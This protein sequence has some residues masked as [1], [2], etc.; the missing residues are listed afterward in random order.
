MPRTTINR[1]TE[2]HAAPQARHLGVCN[3]TASQL[4][5]LTAAFP[6]RHTWPEVNQV[7]LHPYLAQ[8]DLVSP[9][10][11]ISWPIS[12]PI[13]ADLSADLGLRV[14]RG[15]DGVARSP[16]YVPTRP[17]LYLRWPSAARTRSP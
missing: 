13:S 5:E 7:E 12:R 4:E 2:T 6:E 8:P 17:S 15:R 3:F 10:S 1:K 14:R 9:S 11:P 16:S